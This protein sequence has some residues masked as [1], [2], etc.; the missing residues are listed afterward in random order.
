MPYSGPSIQHPIYPQ[1]LLK[2]GLAAHPDTDALIS[3][4]DRWTWRELDEKSS[5]LAGQYLALGLKPGDR[6]ASF[7]PNR[8]ALVDHYLACFKAG[9]VIVP[10][11]YRYTATEIDHAIEVSG[12]TALLAHAERDDDLAAS[13]QVANLPIDVITY[14]A[15]DDRPNPRFEELTALTGEPL[16]NLDRP[17]PGAP[18]AIFF[19]SGSTGK[20][21]GVTHT[22]ESFGYMFASTVAAFKLASDDIT[23][24]ASSMSHLGAFLFGFSS[25]A[26]GAPIVIARTFDAHE[27]IPLL[28]KERPTVLAMLPAALIAIV[29]DH[30]ATPDLFSSLRV[31]RAGG[32]KVSLELEK[33]FTAVAGFPIDEGYGMTE[34]GLIT[35]N[36]PDGEIR[37][38]SVGQTIPGFAL[39]LRDDDHKE[40]PHHTDGRV[41]INTRSSTVGYWE[42]TEATEELFRDGWLDSGDVMSADPDGYMHFRGRKKQIIVHDS[43]NICP[44]E[45]EEALCDHHSVALAGVVGVH[46]PIHGENVRAYVTLEEGHER[47]T[48]QELIHFARERIGYKAPEEIIFLHEMPMTVSGKV[49]R[50]TLKELTHSRHEDHPLR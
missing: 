41:W 19:T 6:V 3:I 10:L 4:E 24:P 21:K 46:D 40:V 13:K 15:T 25:M 18:A 32:D 14:G 20:P 34:V 35:L 5:R 12:A 44:Q 36:P 11:N 38:G 48:V 23:L 43:S 45:V 17:D 30:D 31:C 28:E 1:D 7:M 42:N 8:T 2:A 50:T 37:I 26:S 22:N 16:P 49:N 39:S 29:R 9:L 33:E 47:P 27:V